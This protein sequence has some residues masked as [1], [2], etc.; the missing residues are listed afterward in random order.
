MLSNMPLRIGLLFLTFA[1]AFLFYFLSIGYCKLH[2]RYH[3]YYQLACVIHL[4][5]MVFVDGCTSFGAV[6]LEMKNIDFVV[7][8]SSRS[9]HSIPGVSF[10]IARKEKLEKYESSL[11]YSRKSLVGIAAPLSE[12]CGCVQ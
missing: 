1:D 11:L 4:D 8:T 5:L 3:L 9:L 12:D 2:R 6:P 10:V 7:G